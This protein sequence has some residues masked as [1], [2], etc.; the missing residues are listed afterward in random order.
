MR[1][2]SI[3]QGYQRILEKI[4]E[5]RRKVSIVITTGTRLGSGKIILEH[6]D[7][8]SEIYGGSSAGQSLNYGV[9]T[10]IWNLG[11][12][13]SQ[14]FQV[15]E[16]DQNTTLLDDNNKNV[17]VANASE[18]KSSRSLCDKQCE[19]TENKINEIPKER[20]D[21][22]KRKRNAVSQLIEN[23][24]KHLGKQLSASQRDMILLSE[25]GEDLNTRKEIVSVMKESSQ[26]FSNTI[27]GLCDSIKELSS[28]MSRSIEVLAQRLCAFVVLN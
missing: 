14:H 17:E 7:T 21:W 2:K 19:R 9:N 22:L 4:K 12:E 8:L 28:R 26:S 24:R 23:K 27:E 6:F 13:N 1:Q 5:I 15:V 20:L 11:G 3:K 16:S 18:L 25:S 10:Y